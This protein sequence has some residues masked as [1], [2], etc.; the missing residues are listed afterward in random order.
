MS[1]PER[2]AGAPAKLK[3]V[4][5]VSLVVLA[6]LIAGLLAAA[7][8]E[9]T[10]GAFRA[11]PQYPANL[12]EMNGAEKTAARSRARFQARL[13]EETNKAASAFGLLGVM[14]GVV[15]GLAAGL[16][17]ESRPSK[18]AGAV[19]GGIAGGLAGAGLSLAVVPRFLET[20]DAQTGLPLLFVTHGAIFGAIAV[21]GG[22][23]LAWGLGERRFIIRCVIGAVL[24][25]II[26]TFVFEVINFVA[27]PLLRMY[28]P[29]PLKALPRFILL[30]G[31]AGAIAFGAGLGAGKHR[32]APLAS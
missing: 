5:P 10:Y 4:V 24:G 25:A 22:L 17:R 7:G 15:L 28:E 13:V 19:V 31:V 29:V 14:V 32:R 20:A 2:P 12:S 11:Q 6:G 30:I 21:A 23:A 3:R 8:G 9:L 18:R 1:S 16:A 26:G 27:F